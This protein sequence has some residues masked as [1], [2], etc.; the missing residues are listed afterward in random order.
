MPEKGSH[1]TMY[2]LVHAR[3]ILFQFARD[4]LFSSNVWSYCS[5]GGCAVGIYIYSRRERGGWRE[6][7]GQRSLNFQCTCTCIYIIT[8]LPI[9]EHQPGKLEITGSIPT[10]GSEAFVV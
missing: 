9:I 6:E 7:E 2:D 8:I 1:T 4:T 3:S 5:G 10:Q